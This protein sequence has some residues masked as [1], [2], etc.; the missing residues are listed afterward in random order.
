MIQKFIKRICL[1]LMYYNTYSCEGVWL[2]RMHDCPRENVYAYI[3]QIL[4][5]AYTLL[6]LTLQKFKDTSGRM[7]TAESFI[8]LSFQHG[9]NQ[10]SINIYLRSFFHIIMLASQRWSPKNWLNFKP[11]M[12][13]TS[14]CACHTHNS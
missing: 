9:I 10:D 7:V 13:L 4:S 5:K 11:K 6:S 8:R 3:S 14:K 12:N 2:M 1:L